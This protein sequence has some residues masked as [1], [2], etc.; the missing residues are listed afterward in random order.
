MSDTPGKPGPKPQGFVPWAAQLWPDQVKAIR[1]EGTTR[2]ARQGNA[3]LRDIIDFWGAHRSLFFTWLASRNN[4]PRE[5][6]S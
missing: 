6:L 1:T 4:S 3:V 2:G 5:P